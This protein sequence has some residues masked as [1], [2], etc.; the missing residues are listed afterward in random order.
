M[1][2][3]TPPQASSISF[4]QYTG[5]PASWLKK[6]PKLPSR[7]WLIFLSTTA[8]IGGLY[9]YDRRKCKEIRNHYVEKVKHLS[10][11]PLPSLGMPRKVTVYGSKWP[12]DEDADRSLKYFRKYVKPF[13]VAAAID[14]EMINGGRHGSLAD[15]VADKI[16]YHRR[17]ELGLDSPPPASVIPIPGHGPAD[18]RKRELEGGIIIVG[19]HTFKE[20]MNGL[21]RGWTEPLHVVDKEE[22]LSRELELDDVFDEVDTPD[23]NAGLV[24]DPVIAESPSKIAKGSPFYFP[25]QLSTP[26]PK[27]T[28]EEQLSKD[29]SRLHTSPSSIPPY[30]PILLLP[31]TNFVGF[32]LIPRMIWDFFNQ[33]KKVHDGAEAAYRL[34][35]STPRPILGPSSSFEDCSDKV[36]SSSLSDLSF[37]LQAESFYRSTSLPEEIEKSRTSY[38]EALRPKIIT[39][40]QLARGERE[41]TKDERNYPPPTEVELRAERMKKELRWRS[42]IS[43]WAIINPAAPV[44]WDPRFVGALS[45]YPEEAQD[46]AQTQ[47]IHPS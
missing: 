15:L 33:R 46:M 29:D 8:A 39:A 7:N 12:G 45:V 11:V 24:E 27:S 28:S 37:D 18:K 42:D 20:F 10:E 19:R 17:I 16:K 3:A 43:G 41:P 6:R 34:I 2:L 40:R 9:A 22:L 47:Y 23:P 32:T 5:I 26:P 35:T 36:E 21:K 25:S 14:Y 1:S 4:L 31:F 13:L 30:P 44:S 38:Y